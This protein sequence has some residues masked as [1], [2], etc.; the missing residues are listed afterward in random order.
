MAQPFGPPYLR[1]S[2]F[3]APALTGARQHRTFRR[4]ERRVMAALCGMFHEVCSLRAE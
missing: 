1:L 2:Q 3:G 4:A